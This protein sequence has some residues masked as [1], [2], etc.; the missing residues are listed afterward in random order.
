[1]SRAREGGVGRD[2]K[3]GKENVFP[4]TTQASKDTPREGFPAEA[5]AGLTRLRGSLGWPHVEA[6]AG[7]TWKVGWLREGFFLLCYFTDFHPYFTDFA[8]RCV[9]RMTSCQ[10]S[11]AKSKGGEGGATITLVA[12]LMGLPRTPKDEQGPCF[13]VLAWALGGFWPP[14]LVCKVLGPTQCQPL[15]QGYKDR[16]GQIS[17]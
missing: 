8:G 4:A 2:V 17:Q 15:T 16:T 12:I 14:G 3:K 6:L 5:S 7:L 1:M 13:V 9:C 11:S 10:S